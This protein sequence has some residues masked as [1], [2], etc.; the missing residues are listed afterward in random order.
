MVWV[1]IT[2]PAPVCLSR[3]RYTVVTMSKPRSP[4]RPDHAPLEVNEVGLIAIGTVAWVVALIVM[5]PFHSSLSAHGHGDW[6]WIAVA[7]IGGG[8]FGMWFTY[9][10]RRAR[11][12]PSPDG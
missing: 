6:P 11:R 5:L 4:R 8:F 1:D 7:A 9:R 12:R 2:V 3:E 10:H